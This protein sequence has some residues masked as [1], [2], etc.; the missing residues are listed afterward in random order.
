VGVESLIKSNPNRFIES[1][2]KTDL[3]CNWFGSNP[4]SQTHFKDHQSNSVKFN[5]IWDGYSVVSCDITSLEI[6]AEAANVMRTLM[7]S[8]KMASMVVRGYMFIWDADEQ[9]LY[10]NGDLVFS[11]DGEH[12]LTV[13]GGYTHGIA[14]WII[15]AIDPKLLTKPH[16]KFESFWK[17]L[18]EVT[19]REPASISLLEIMPYLDEWLKMLGY[20]LIPEVVWHDES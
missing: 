16:I 18:K 10:L 15:N 12:G 13:M 4:L 2:A 3:I 8:F 11:E 20:N 7:D 9:N 5:L 14:T 19:E 6:A 17:I 1:L